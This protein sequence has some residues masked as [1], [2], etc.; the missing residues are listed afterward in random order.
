MKGEKVMDFIFIGKQKLLRLLKVQMN[1]E[2]IQLKDIQYSR[3]E[4]YN[5]Y[6]CEK[7]VYIENDIHYEINNLYTEY[8][9][10]TSTL[11]FEK[12]VRVS[13][14]SYKVEQKKILDLKEI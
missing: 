12:V 9:Y 13:E 8:R 7:V 1:R 5:I 2:D 11:Y 14:N 10:P 3:E 6:K 4:N